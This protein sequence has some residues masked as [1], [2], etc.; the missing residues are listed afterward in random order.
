[1]EKGFVEQNRWNE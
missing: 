1:L